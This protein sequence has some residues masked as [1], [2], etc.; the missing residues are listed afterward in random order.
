[1][2][3]VWIDDETCI[4]A[5]IEDNGMCAIRVNDDA[6]CL[7]IRKAASEA[8]GE[9]NFFH[10]DRILMMKRWLQYP[11]GRLKNQCTRNATHQF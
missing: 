1:M 3:A 9:N 2:R 8:E 5:S 11:S 6:L 10:G 4:A 7:N